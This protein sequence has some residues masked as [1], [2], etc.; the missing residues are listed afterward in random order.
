M[1]TLR[2]KLTGHTEVIVSRWLGTITELVDKYGLT[3]DI[4]L[5]KSAENYADQLTRVERSCL[6]SNMPCVHIAVRHR[7]L[8]SY[9]QQIQCRHH[10]GVQRTFD[11]ARCK[12]GPDIQLKTVKKLIQECLL[13]RQ[14]GLAP[15]K[16][17][18]GTLEIPQS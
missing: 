10:F 9:V 15:V 4:Q 14:I 18:K 2:P 8:K 6:A 1:N 3:V 16:W 12:L 7:D 11:L 5:V 13:N 17:E